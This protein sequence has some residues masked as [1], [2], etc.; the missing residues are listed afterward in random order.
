MLAVSVPLVIYFL[1]VNLG[2]L[3]NSMGGHTETERPLGRVARRLAQVLPV[4]AGLGGVAAAALVAAAG[5]PA[6]EIAAVAVLAVVVTGVLARA[7]Y[8]RPRPKAGRSATPTAPA[9]G[10]RIP[11]AT[12]RAEEGRLPW[13]LVNAIL[14]VVFATLSFGVAALLIAAIVAVPVVFAVLIW[15]TWWGCDAPAAE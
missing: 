12:P 1:L 3:A 10:P 7:I 4:L 6:L 14:L 8:H 5:A 11:V 9:G 13:L 2:M 15:L